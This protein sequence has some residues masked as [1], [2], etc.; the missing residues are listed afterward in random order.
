MNIRSMVRGS[1]TL[2]TVLGLSLSVTTRAGAAPATWHVAVGGATPDN[3][4][5]ALRYHPTNLMVD[6]GDS[7][8]WSVA[9]DER[10]TVTFLSGQPRPTNAEAPV[11]D[12][13]YAGTGL[14]S[15]GAIFPGKAY[16]LAF[17]SA[18]VYAY[19][20]LFHP[21]MKGSVTVQQSGAAYPQTQAQLDALAS[22]EIADNLAGGPALLNSQKLT[23]STNADGSITHNTFAGLG[24]GTI[25]AMRFFPSA[26][27]IKVGDTLTWVDTDPSMPHTVTFA[28]DGKY[29]DFPSP[30][31]VTPAG[32]A[33]YDGTAFTNSGF[34]TPAGTPGNHPYTLKF[35]KAGVY[36]YHCLIHDD[37]GMVGVVIVGQTESI[38]L[39]AAGH[40][41]ASSY[42]V[43]RGGAD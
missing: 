22:S 33:T 24:N 41:T 27:S 14:H 12:N 38:P 15:S 43:A 7:V 32:G 20:C 26:L 2:F 40:G 11:G 17:P 10:H 35:T 6:A 34:I 30:A 19:I 3:S 42:R 37:L 23:A 25:A 39:A 18:G 4:V 29:P 5:V 13:V 21:G 31:A 28:P 9:G 36:M 1:I 16:T 8:A